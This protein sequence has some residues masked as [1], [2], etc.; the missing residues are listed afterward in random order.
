M[1]FAG[2]PGKRV[3][4]LFP[5]KI[6]VHCTIA[7]GGLAYKAVPLAASPGHQAGPGL[8]S[9]AYQAALLL[10]SMNMCPRR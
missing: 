8:T 6:H 3:V 2:A 5:E 1:E 10:L 9:C 4:R 7:G